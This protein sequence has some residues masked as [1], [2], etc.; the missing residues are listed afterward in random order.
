MDP[1]FTIFWYHNRVILPPVLWYTAFRTCYP[2][3][4]ISS[5]FIHRKQSWFFSNCLNKK[6]FFLKNMYMNVVCKMSDNLFGSPCATITQTWKI[7]LLYTTTLWH[8]LD[9][10][11][12]SQS[13]LTGIREADTFTSY[14]SEVILQLI[15]QIYIGI[16]FKAVHILFNNKKMPRVHHFSG[17]WYAA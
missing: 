16:V 14:L 15:S 9:D 8:N 1:W 11:Y 2:L 10:W 12:L 3:W 4:H 17:G 13:Y 6:Y 5:W 7:T